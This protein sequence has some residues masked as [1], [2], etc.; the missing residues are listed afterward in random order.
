MLDHIPHHAILNISNNADCFMKFHQLAS[1]SSNKTFCA[2]GDDAGPCDGDSGGGLFISI[3]N[4]WHLKGIV[5]VAFFLPTGQCEVS[6]YSV[7]TD[8]FQFTSWIEPIVR[9]DAEAG[10]INYDSYVNN[11]CFG[12]E[13]HENQS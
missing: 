1:I 6:K 9:S 10:R 8:V 3:D 2:S 11:E 12:N 13:N 5:S 4:R 7:F